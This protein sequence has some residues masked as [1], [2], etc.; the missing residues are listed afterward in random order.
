MMS[1]LADSLR[2]LV[3]VVG[4]RPPDFPTNFKG[5]AFVNGRGDV[6]RTGPVEDDALVVAQRVVHEHAAELRPEIDRLKE[7]PKLFAYAEALSGPLGHAEVRSLMQ[8]AD[9]P[10]E[11][12]RRFLFARFLVEYFSR[13]TA[14]EFDA[15]AF[16]ASCKPFLVL[17]H[18]QVPR[19][20]RA[21]IAGLA[22]NDRLALDA[23]IS[24]ESLTEDERSATALRVERESR[25]LP[26][27][28]SRA[29]C[30]V[31]VSFEGE[32]TADRKSATARL[33]LAMS[34][35]RLVHNPD[36]RLV[37]V[38][39]RIATM[40]WT[41]R[42]STCAP[43]DRLPWLVD[44]D[45]QLSVV[46]GASAVTWFAIERSVNGGRL[47]PALRRWNDACER[48]RDDDRLVDSWVGL[49]TL[50]GD[51]GEVTFKLALRM[52]AV[53][54]RG[55][56]DREALFREVKKAYGGRSK[57]VHGAEKAPADIRGLARQAHEWL[58]EGVQWLAAREAAY[59]P[60]SI[61]VS[62]LHGS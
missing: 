3:Q 46:S 28:T 2:G 6:L 31:T 5:N 40:P 1:R 60:D 7:D 24:V 13:S 15:V 22:V 27:A 37:L 44:P 18:P 36:A 45:A 26:L 49:E 8:R 4:P 43:D 54:R 53:L 48:E 47:L 57:V 20:L 12:V 35:L 58:R 25:W 30:L 33:V 23:G 21:L 14:A 11:S 52:A 38:E 39:D 51:D 9:L 41:A 10:E 29:A 19:E 50:F 61:E 16:E 62:L 59:K 56:Q 42:V 17:E 34:V 32:G 55:G